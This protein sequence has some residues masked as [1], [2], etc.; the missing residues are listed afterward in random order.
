MTTVSVIEQVCS[1]LLCFLNATW[2]LCSR[3]C[4]LY[5]LPHIL[6]REDACQG[7]KPVISYSALSSHFPI[8]PPCEPPSSP[9]SSVCT[10]LAGSSREVGFPPRRCPSPPA[11]SP[12]DRCDAI[13]A[14]LMDLQRRQCTAGGA[15]LHEK[16]A[17]SGRGWAGRGAT[18]KDH[19]QRWEAWP[20]LANQCSWSYGRGD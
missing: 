11:W 14:P 12:C 10:W 4:Q 1:T 5:L 3:K 2:H 18:P 20:N 16:P 19:L 8:H 17:A 7:D 6:T 9:S 15:G 13:A